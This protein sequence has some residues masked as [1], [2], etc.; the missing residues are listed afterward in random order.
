MLKTERIGVNRARNKR[1]LLGTLHVAALVVASHLLATCSAVAPTID[2]SHNMRILKLPKSTQV[3]ELIYRLKGSDGD[4]SSRLTFG[5][6]GLGAR[7]LLDVVP[8][9]RSWNEADVFLRA[10]L[11]EPIYNLTVYVTDGNKST[12]V[13]STIIV[14]EPPAL[15]PS[16]LPAGAGD[17]PTAGNGTLLGPAAEGPLSLSPF[18]RPRQVFNVP[19]NLQPG[20]SL[21]TISVRESHS[22]ELPVRFELRGQGADK[23]QLN[24]VFGP[25]GLSRG[26]LLLAQPVD[27]ERQNLFSLKVLAL[28]AW[29]ESRYDTRNVASLDIVVTV[30]DVQDTA[31]Q[32]RRGPD[33]IRV[34]NEMPAGELVA[35]VAA[36]DGDLSDQ[37]PVHYALDA[38]SPLASYFDIDKLSGEITLRRPAR[39]LALHAA[40]DSAAWSQLTVFASEVP[41]TSSYDHLWPPMFAR[42]ELPLTLVELANEPPQF[43]GGWQTNE[44][45]R[46]GQRTL[47]GFLRE[48]PPAQ[49]D[50]GPAKAEG[51]PADRQLVGW[52]T[53][54]SSSSSPAPKADSLQSYIF[55]RPVALDLG[56]GSNG[57]F[58]LSLEG[59]DAH[60]FEL[61]PEYQVQKQTSFNLFVAARA[62]MSLFDRDNELPPRTFQLELVARD[63]GS[64]RLSSRIRCAIELLEVNDNAPQ[65]E[66]DLFS[67]SVFESAPLGQV[68]GVLRARDPDRGQRVRYASLTG[69]NSNL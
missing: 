20:E 59:P 11:A 29:S 10:P 9:A 2:Y 18:V 43:L 50:G 44:S 4:A 16:P 64:P 45:L 6:S 63:F 42:L 68:V 28:N 25:R 61:E 62:N 38:A 57:T 12:Q 56:L 22:S 69:R 41:D 47:H 65:F 40:W 46:L 66:S 35:R 34:S 5:V 8:V 19:E 55:R 60:L 21:G 36:E 15:E 33:R 53:N 17:Q 27:Y 32:F 30:G 23:F 24:Y 52:Y 13:E 1:W 51:Q 3:G 58:E 14:T 49:L 48:L 26:Q 39:E 37:R 67:F 31:P 7:S 54:F